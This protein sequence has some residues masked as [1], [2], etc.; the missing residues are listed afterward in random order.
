MVHPSDVLLFTV[1]IIFLNFKMLYDMLE[2]I[3][4]IKGIF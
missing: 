4:S 2:E 3:K 1:H